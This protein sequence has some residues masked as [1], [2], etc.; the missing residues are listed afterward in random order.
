MIF[1]VTPMRSRFGWM[2]GLLM[3]LRL[4]FVI[5]GTMRSVVTDFKQVVT[6]QH[7]MLTDGEIRAVRAYRELESRAMAENVT[8]AGGSGDV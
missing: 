6:E 8:T 4:G 2:V 3:I 5:G 1:G 7:P